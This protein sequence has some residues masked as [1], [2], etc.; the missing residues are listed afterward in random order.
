M[1]SPNKINIL[2]SVQ[3]RASGP[4]NKAKKDVRSFRDELVQFNRRLFTASAVYATFSQGFKK[5]FDMAGVGAQFDFLR[6]Q[7]NKTFSPEYLTTLRKVSAGT[8]DA[9]SM[10]QLAVQNHARGLKK[11]E[12]E[13]IFGL[14]VKA[15]KLLGTTTSD[16][17]NRMSRALHGLS[18]TGMQQFMVALNTNNQFKNMNLLIGR[19]TK[20]LNAAGKQTDV[21]RKIALRELNLAMATVSANTG[22]AKEL[23]MAWKASLDSVRQVIGS[24]I[25]RAIAPLGAAMSR[26]N[27]DVFDKF[28]SILDAGTPKLKSMRDGLV[29][30]AQ[31]GGSILATAAGLTGGFSLLFLA[32]G[33]LNLSIMGI[34]SAFT[35]FSAAL[36]GA[37]GENRSWLQFLSDVGTELKFYWQA[38]TSYKDGV[39][40]FSG[41]VINRLSQMS[42]QSRNRIIFIAKGFV[43]A[44]SALNG[45]KMGVQSAMDVLSK[46][47]NKF[48]LF[49]DKQKQ[50]SKNWDK[51]AQHLGA[52]LGILG[53][54]GAATYGAFKVAKMVKGIGGS[55]F[56]GAKRGASALRPLYVFSV[57][58]LATMGGM[59]KGMV[60]VLGGFVG[61]LGTIAKMLAPLLGK[62]GL[63]AGVGY[64]SYKIAGAMGMTKLGN[65]IGDT[66][67]DAING[68]SGA[69]M[70]FDK[71]AGGR[72]LGSSLD[73]I[74][75]PSA[76]KASRENDLSGLLE[77]LSGAGGQVNT[78]QLNSMAKD[79][80]DLSE[81]TALI[82]GIKMFLET[83]AP[84]QH[85]LNLNSGDQVR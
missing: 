80:I 5:A 25:A 10:M 52:L 70:E 7:F 27:W 50:F 62:L 30:F 36:K 68:N 84:N 23:L 49:A 72:S 45:F 53:V 67:Y 1:A 57:N 12:T 56:G 63:L 20:G 82:A 13:Q 38:F 41:E 35:L 61:K 28:N 14:S 77:T 4:M 9:M 81:M 6:Q 31:I 15:A 71:G 54:A 60:G 39:S 44:R 47:F 65:W 58:S 79:G 17:A 2:I 19:L 29:D 76:R 69:G 66:A 42:E 21:F 37:K 55:V 24:F 8:M 46:F 73:K 48:G 11:A 74:S 40:T 64:G 33:P 85:V 83:N 78:S 43:L 59:G 22:D 32:T 34:V 3:N 51:T 18:V 16:A 75:D 26:L